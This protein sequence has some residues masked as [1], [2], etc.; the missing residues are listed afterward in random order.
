MLA[1]YVIT[2]ILIAIAILYLIKALVES[3]RC[4]FGL[5]TAYFLLAAM[6]GVDFGGVE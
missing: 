1:R 6:K 4:A 5:A 2:A 3:E